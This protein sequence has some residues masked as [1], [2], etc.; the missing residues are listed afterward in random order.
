VLATVNGIGDFLSSAT[1][2]IL[3]SIT[4]RAAMGLV[5]VASVV[6]SAIIANNRPAR[7]G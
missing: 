3:W 2:G 5:V 6:G 7:A 4:P 1:V